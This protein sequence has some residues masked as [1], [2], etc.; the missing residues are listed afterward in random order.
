MVCSMYRVGGGGG[1][2]G[3][4]GAAAPAGD[5]I[6]GRAGGNGRAGAPVVGGG[7]PAAAGRGDGPNL[8]RPLA[9]AETSIGSPEAMGAH[10]DAILE[11]IDVAA[12]NDV[13][14]I[15][16][17][18]G[19][20]RLDVGI[21]Y[22]RGADNAVAFLHT[23]VKGRAEEKGVTLVI[24]LLNSKGFAAPAMSMFDH[25][26]WGVDMCKRV[27]SPRVK[28]LYDIYH[29]Q[30]MDGFIVQTMRDNIQYI[31]HIH[32]GSITGRHELDDTQELNWRFIA[33]AI[34]DLNYKGFVTHEWTPTPGRNYL[35]GL[36]Q[37]I[38]V[39]RV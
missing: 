20:R 30:I 29:A 38:E 4:A 11:A 12:A 16:L 27:N 32:T 18:A 9:P 36:K 37:A 5:A 21:D 31:G 6:G 22:A 33:Q 39:M 7:A 14:N 2:R 34:A 24:E 17:T 28:N 23:A 19:S 3:A 13:P 26:A 15:F 1:G 10:R 8:D 35:D 25:M